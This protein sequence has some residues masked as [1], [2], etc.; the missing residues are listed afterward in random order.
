M[1]RAKDIYERIKSSGLDA[2]KA[3][4]DARESENLFL[5]FKRSSDNGGGKKLHDNDRKNLSRAISGFSNSE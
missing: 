5:D 4:I 3:F 2:V 1:S